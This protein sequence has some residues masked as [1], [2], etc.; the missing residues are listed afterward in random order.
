MGARPTQDKHE[1]QKEI[2]AILQSQPALRV[3]GLARRFGVTTETIRRDLDHLHRE[4]RLSRTYGGA[5]ARP[6]TY[7][8]ALGDRAKLMIAERTAIAAR[9]A[10]LVKP[11]EALM[12]DAGATTV[13]VAVRLAAHCNHLTVLTNS[14]G[15]AVALA[16][17]PTMKVIMVPG[18]FDGAEGAILGSD[19]ITFLRSYRAD[20]AI[21][22][23]TGV[24][25]DGLHDAN[26][27]IA[28]IKRT[29]IEQASEV[30]Y[31]AD[32]QKFEKNS[33]VTVAPLSDI[34]W[35]VTDIAPAVDLRAA[36]LANGVMVIQAMPVEA[37]KKPARRSITSARSR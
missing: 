14:V 35:I 32:H 28:A 2:V 20:K 25:P 27:E 18:E 17:N 36:L 31:V 34:D 8:P 16:T 9:A 21:I 33:L 11:G 1:R 29:M 30:I 37:A 7:E 13:H 23:S 15:V 12:I 10:E 4:G 19:A 24:T 5:T 26:R 6:F 22:G 3:Q